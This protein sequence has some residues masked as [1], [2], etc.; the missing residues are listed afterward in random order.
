M[1]LCECGC[2]Q[3]IIKEGNR[4]ARGHNLRVDNP[5]KNPIVAGK[6]R[7]ANIGQV[8]WNKGLKGLQVAWNKGIK[9]SVESNKTSFTEGQTPWNKGL[10]VITDE[11]VAKLVQKSNIGRVVSGETLE[12]MRLS[13][14]GQVAWNKGK[15]L[16]DTHKE[17]VG[18]P[19]NVRKRMRGMNIQPNKPEQKLIELISHN[20]L[21]FVYVG[22]GSVI[23]ERKCPDFI[24][25]NGR[26]QVI[27]LFGDYWHAPNITGKSREGE[28]QYRIDIFAKYGFSTL[29]IWEHELKEPSKVLTKLREF[30]E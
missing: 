30:A 20:Q 13:H 28:E 2:G 5:M 9:G 10:T 29:I 1:T 22:D 12:K 14:I 25:V 18:S 3:L 6:V 4:F 24:N 27:E 19:E 15:R 16:S 17:K 7:S 21:P 11:R 26:K 23:I 8:A